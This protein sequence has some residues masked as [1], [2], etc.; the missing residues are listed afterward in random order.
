[1]SP[2]GYVRF[3]ELYQKLSDAGFSSE[4]KTAIN[5]I[6]SC[7]REIEALEQFLKKENDNED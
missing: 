4:E 1:L 5:N 3:K 2:A 6:Q 7:E